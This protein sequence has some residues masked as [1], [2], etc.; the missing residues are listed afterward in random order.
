ML[1]SALPKRV[2]ARGRDR[3]LVVRPSESA[4]FDEQGLT[5]PEAFIALPGEI[6]SGHPDRHVMRV[7]LGDRRFAYLKREHRIRWK[8][9]FRNWRAN[10][11]AISK[12]VREGRVLQLI[13]ERVLPGPRWLA[14]G[15]TRDG[16]AF[17]LIE[18]AVAV[19]DLRQAWPD[20][21]APES[22]AIKLGRLCGEM[23]AAGVDHPDLYSKHFLIDL[24][25]QAVTLIDWQRVQFFR[26]VSW[27]RR[28]HALA[29]LVATLPAF[30]A[31]ADNG[32]NNLFLW[33]Y[34]RAGND[35]D[36]P[37]VQTLSQWG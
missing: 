3:R 24:P 26:H 20:V 31:G 33:S 2:F 14:F 35:I 21:D 1:V 23:H 25:T 28:V 5:T 34:L 22:L 8:V 18:E 6:V 27:R 11:G 29:T 19:V 17:L 12:S 10:F 15:E 13:E 9:R 36:A 32:L 16:R 7:Q 4:A 37:D 30:E